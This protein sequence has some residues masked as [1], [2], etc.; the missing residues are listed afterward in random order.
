MSELLQILCSEASFLL[1][2]AGHH[3]LVF[4]SCNHGFNCQFAKSFLKCG[5]IFGYGLAKGR[6]LGEKG[7][8]GE[9]RT[10]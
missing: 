6:F 2:F 4:L 10:G 8:K 3:L 5:N 9:T 1:G 7:P